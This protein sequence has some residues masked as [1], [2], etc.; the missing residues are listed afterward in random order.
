VKQASLKPQ[1]RNAAS[2]ATK[3]M[4]TDKSVEVIYDD[5]THHIKMREPQIDGDAATAIVTGRERAPIGYAA[6]VCAK[7]K[8]DC[9]TS[10]GIDPR[11][12]RNSDP[13][14]FVVIGPER[15]I[16][17]ADRA[18]AGGGRFRSSGK[19]PAD[20][21]AMTATFDHSIC[22]IL[23]RAGLAQPLQCPGEAASAGIWAQ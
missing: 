19:S 15:S 7:M 22:T 6:A 21:A 14:I 23:Q 1:I 4:K 12:P 9:P 8:A 20:G 13:L 10:P 5:S 17:S 11:R 16:A 2:I 18:I 3:V